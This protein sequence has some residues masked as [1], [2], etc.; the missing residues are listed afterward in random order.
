MNEITAL[1]TWQLKLGN[2]ASERPVTPELAMVIATSHPHF[3]G[4]LPTEVLLYC[5]DQEVVMDR[6]V[7][8]ALYAEDVRAITGMTEAEWPDRIVIDT[9]SMSNSAYLMQRHDDRG[10]DG[11]TQ[12]SL[13]GYAL[14]RS[15]DFTKYMEAEHKF[16]SAR[17]WDAR[18]TLRDERYEIVSPITYC[19][20]CDTDSLTSTWVRDTPWAYPR[21][22]NC[23]MC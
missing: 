22:P 12:Y 7:Y 13:R 5:P 4:Y 17:T 16:M 9:S 2:R 23:G 8:Y 20:S 14:L 21:C 10:D 1:R 3:G 19:H 6:W 15:E 18:H 11:H